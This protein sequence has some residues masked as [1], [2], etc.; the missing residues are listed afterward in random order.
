MSDRSDL[1]Q[2]I[3]DL[4]YPSDDAEDRL[5]AR[6]LQ[7]ILATKGFTELREIKGKMEENPEYM[8][9]D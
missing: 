6:T 9:K 2:K 4:R 5:G 8:P 1:R 7:L 3:V